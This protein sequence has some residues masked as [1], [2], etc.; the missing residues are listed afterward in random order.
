[1]NKNKIGAEKQENLMTSNIIIED[2]KAHLFEII[3][4]SGLPSSVQELIAKDFY[5]QVR[6]A[7]MQIYQMERARYEES[8]KESDAQNA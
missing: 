6:D 7:S 3:S 8:L 2:V 1:M 5:T 4:N